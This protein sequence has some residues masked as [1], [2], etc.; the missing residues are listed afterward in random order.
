MGDRRGQAL[1]LGNASRQPRSGVRADLRAHPASR[2]ASRR[3]S[4]PATRPACRSSSTGGRSTCRPTTPR[5][6]L[7]DVRVSEEAILGELDGGLALAQRFVHEN[8]IRQAAS[9]LGAAV[10][11]IE[12]A[13]RWAR[14]RVVWGKPLWRN[15]AHPVPA[16]GAVDGSRA[17]ARAGAPDGSG[18]RPPPSHG[19]HPSGGDGQLPRQPAGVRG[20]RPGDADAAAGSATRATCPSSTSTATIAAIGSPRAARR[21]RF[22]R[23]LRSCSAVR[24]EPPGRPRLGR[25]TMNATAPQVGGGAP[26]S[27]SRIRRGPPTSPRRARSRC[28]CSPATT[29][30]MRWPGTSG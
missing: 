30:R 6:R 21:C 20:C 14:E 18:A 26:A 12:E 25:W 24:S 3:S 11:C 27:A 15:Q 13:V 17:G 9:S 2:A 5:S 1:Q 28:S 7:T 10:F 4:S 8:R 16:G 29:A 19:G 23:S 22:A